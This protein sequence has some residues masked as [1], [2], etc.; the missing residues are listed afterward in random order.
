MYRGTGR[1]GVMDAPTRAWLA[2]RASDERI[3][4]RMRASARATAQ[5]AGLHGD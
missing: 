5:L 1:I 4:K 3:E 2:V